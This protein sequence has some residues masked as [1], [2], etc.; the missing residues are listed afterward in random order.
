MNTI[1]VAASKPY[2]V[3]VGS[4]LLQE[5]G[6]QIAQVIAPCT[7]AILTDDTVDSLYGA[8]LQ[9]S[10]EAA[11]FSVVRFVFP[12]GEASKNLAVFGQALNFLAEN[13]L[14]RSDLVVALGGG[15]CGDLAGFVA[16]VYLRGIPYVQIPTT[17]LAAVDS[18]VGGKTAVDLP[19]GKNLAGAFY[20]PSLVLCDPDTLSTLPQR[21]FRE[22]CAE[23]I[24]CGV[25]IGEPFFT[26]LEQTPIEQQ[27]E[28]VI[29]ACV[30]YKRDVVERDEFDRGD[31]QLLNL[32]HTIGHAVETNADFS[33][34]H[35]ECV[36]IGLAAVSR[37]AVKHGLCPEEACRRICRL[38]QQYDLPTE[39]DQTA[40]AIL[41]LC[42]SDKKI[43]A[44]KIKL[45]VPQDIGCCR[46]HPMVL[47]QLQD[48]IE[49]GVAHD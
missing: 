36:A 32:G 27:L 15:V 33:L 7:A 9:Q 49:K 19:A 28:A 16:S 10:L 24:K 39:T 17:L 40:E 3:L 14:S 34:F 4:G 42:R 8:A 18:S 38:L 43:A 12:H 21:T 6:Q 11:G 26:A 5:A 22:G 29:C 48:W 44:G 13:R 2:A 47:A 30:S 1:P 37:A 20:Q 31:R 41:T 46:L 23:V 25:L 35:G 45:V